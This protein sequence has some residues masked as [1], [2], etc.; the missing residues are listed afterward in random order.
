MVILPRVVKTEA[1]NGKWVIPIS[2][3]HRIAER[4]KKDH[5][6]EFFDRQ[7]P[8]GP[9]IVIER[10]GVQEFADALKK[11]AQEI[12][13]LNHEEIA[14]ECSGR[15]AYQRVNI[16][17]NGLRF[18]SFHYDNGE[19]IRI[20]DVSRD[21]ESR[22]TDLL[23]NYLERDL[24]AGLNFNSA[25]SLGGGR[26]VERVGKFL[27]K[28]GKRIVFD[29]DFLL[30]KS[31][32]LD[33]LWMKYFFNTC[34]TNEWGE[35]RNLSLVLRCR[36]QEADT[37]SYSI[38]YKWGHIANCHWL[39]FEWDGDGNPRRVK[40]LFREDK[41][42][43]PDWAGCVTASEIKYQAMALGKTLEPCDPARVFEYEA[44]SAQAI[45]I[46]K[47]IFGE[48]VDFSK[49]RLDARRTAD[50]IAGTVVNE[51]YA[52]HVQLLQPA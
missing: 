4:M 21:I 36:M 19:P 38:G 45:G 39:E 6:K 50:N 52:D 41:D 35:H 24:G 48:D 8:Q 14:K 5:K 37:L 29:S 46:G 23:W 10:A 9:W 30:K 32:D 47:K 15:V 22:K 44:S 42:R 26:L 49:Y 11:D 18:V 17:D 34:K 1:L 20:S 33:S 12:K 13:A 40:G 43:I 51:A 28:D 2:K 31:Y 25:E 3:S 7:V 16:L 27:D